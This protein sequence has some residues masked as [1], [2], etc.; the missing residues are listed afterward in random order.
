MDF[1]LTEEHRMIQKAVRRFAEQEITPTIR[2]CGQD[3][4]F[5]RSLLPKMA[6]QGSLGYLY[7]LSTYTNVKTSHCC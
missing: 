6:I 5:D 2:K 3:Q 1:A 4:I 7:V